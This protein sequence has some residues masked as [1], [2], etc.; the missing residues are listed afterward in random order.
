MKTRSTLLVLTVAALLWGGCRHSRDLGNNPLAADSTQTTNIPT[1]RAC[2]SAN[3]QCEIYNMELNGML[4]MME[5]SVI[6]ASVSKVV[7]L[8]RMRLTPD[9]AHVYA[10]LTQ[11][12]YRGDYAT[13]NARSGYKIDFKTIQDI[14]MDAYRNRKPSVD[15]VM[16]SAKRQDTIHLHLTRYSTVREQSYPLTIPDRA[17]PF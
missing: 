15:I 9:S 6:W 17:R 14:L 13:L 11:Q 8:G 16:K 10:R 1:K 4:R 7:E 12:Y 2:F 5:D 3:F